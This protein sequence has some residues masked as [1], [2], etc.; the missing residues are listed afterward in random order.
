MSSARAALR[1]W[2]DL[3]VEDRPFGTGLIN[4]TWRGT[5]RGQPVIVQRVHPAFAPHV[6]EDI[7]R[8]TR[9]L[10]ARGVRTPLLLP[11]REGKLCSVDEEGR[12]Y[13]VLTFI[14]GSVAFDKVTSAKMAHEAGAVVGRFHAAIADLE[15]TY[16]HVRP[17]IHDLSFRRANLDRALDAHRDHRLYADVARLDERARAL[18]PLALP[19][20]TTRGRHAH[21][22]LKISNIL[23]AED[24]AALCLVDLDTLASMPFPFEMGDALRSWCNPRREDEP[25]AHVDATF[26]EAALAGH[27]RGAPALRLEADEIER[28]TAGLLTIALE[29]AERFLTDALE[30]RYFRFDPARYPALGEHNRERA[31]GQLELAES[32]RD[33]ASTLEKLA[34]GALAG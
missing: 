33:H 26:F 16:V 5:H 22:D 14:E 31:R 18:E 19:L 11:T 30:E 1:V 4:A 6:H 15:H 28:V 12:S 34:R 24:G 3:V 23:F 29:L 17:G 32:V 13:R 20:T 2:D 10:A 8:V 21:G 9:H 27:R 7:D 25:G